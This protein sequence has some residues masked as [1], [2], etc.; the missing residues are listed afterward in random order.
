MHLSSHYSSRS[1]MVAAWWP[2]GVGLLM[3][4]YVILYGG[5]PKPS[6]ASE[7]VV[8]TMP[9][10]ANLRDK[11]ESTGVS[12]KG[13]CPKCPQKECPITNDLITQLQADITTLREQCSSPA[14]DRGEKKSVV[15]RVVSNSCPSPPPQASVSSSTDGVLDLTTQPSAVN[16]W[17]T[18]S[19]LL[20]R[21][22]LTEEVDK[23]GHSQISDTFTL[24]E[25]NERR[26][27]SFDPSR[28]RAWLIYDSKG[29]MENDQYIF[30]NVKLQNRKLIVSS[31]LDY[32]GDTQPIP[33]SHRD[34]TSDW[35]LGLNYEE[36]PS[37]LSCTQP[38]LDA[39]TTTYYYLRPHTFFNLYHAHNDNLLPAWRA[40]LEMNNGLVDPSHQNILIL[41][42]PTPSDKN[43]QDASAF[44]YVVSKLFDKVLRFDSQEVQEGLCMAN[45]RVGRNIK[46]FWPS[47]SNV[48]RYVSMSVLPT[49]RV[50]VLERSG[51][52]FPNV[53]RS[54]P[55]KITLL[56]RNGGTRTLKDT[57]IL[58]SAF[59]ELSLTVN[60]VTMESISDFG[61]QI[62]VAAESDIL[63]GVH[64]AGLTHTLYQ[65]PGSLL[66]Q[67]GPS[68]LNFWD[69]N[70][71][72]R[73]STLAGVGYLYWNEIDPNWMHGNG[74]GKPDVKL[75]PNGQDAGD[76]SRDIRTLVAEALVT[77]ATQQNFVL[78]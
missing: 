54:W 28:S 20:E 51:I 3:I 22:L 41:G 47:F 13:K 74:V 72:H 53:P 45:F 2:Y 27:T 18:S 33:L 61:E 25:W 35:P 32:F 36:S 10:I 76:T 64:G 29:K 75:R 63:I 66:V 70:L 49:F 38:A 26:S 46:F 67:L 23:I 39:T 77:W 34:Y 44:N 65:R 31:N 19:V 12:P 50:R 8:P 6:E 56:M 42:D 14:N 59:E 55:P 37:P 48:A 16:A 7:A 21:A 52:A 15:E 24:P 9:K 73:M 68:A 58:I 69:A 62:K 57:D 30:H 1:S 17:K 60:T 78:Q 4:L 5:S 11:K 43:H 40:V 71:Y